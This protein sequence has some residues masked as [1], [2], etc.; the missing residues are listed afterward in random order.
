M[1]TVGV[2]S[3][4]AKIASRGYDVYKEASRRKARD[5]EEVKAEIETIQSSKIVDPY[6]YTI[7]AKE[8]Y[9]KGWKTVGHI[10][11]YK[12]RLISRHVY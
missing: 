2:Y 9:F 12:E 3:F 7:R 4:E 8:E 11:R 10:E 5:G 1:T 6:P